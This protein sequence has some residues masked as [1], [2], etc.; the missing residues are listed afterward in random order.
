MSEQAR[1]DLKSP[2][3]VK[4]PGRASSNGHNSAKFIASGGS[5]NGAMMM[6]GMS[7]H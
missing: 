2:A 5:H 1:E 4:S 3:S 7:S 6:T